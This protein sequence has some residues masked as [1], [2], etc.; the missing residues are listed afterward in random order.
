MLSQFLAALPSCLVSG[1]DE[2]DTL[3]LVYTAALHIACF[4]FL[5]YI[6]GTYS[7]IIPLLSGVSDDR[8][9]L[10]HVPCALAPLLRRHGP[11]TGFTGLACGSLLRLPAPHRP[12]EPASAPPRAKCS[13]LGLESADG[14]PTARALQVRTR[15]SRPTSRGTV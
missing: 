7:L 9:V 2:C 1:K 6:V 14:A 10:G 4:L 11:F 13:S 8:T 5:L 3:S 12:E 15:R